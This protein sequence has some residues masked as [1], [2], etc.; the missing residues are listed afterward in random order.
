MNATWTRFVLG[1]LGVFA[2][3]RVDAQISVGPNRQ[4]ST[5]NPQRPHYELWADIDPTNPARMVACSFVTLE[6]GLTTVVYASG[7]AGRTWG[8]SKL[9]VDMQMGGD[10]ICTFGHDGMAYYAVLGRAK[11]KGDGLWGMWV[12]RSS[13][14]G[15]MWSEPTRLPIIDREYVV[16]DGG[17]GKYHGRVYINGTGTVAMMA[18]TALFT[19]I[20]LYT[21]EDGG[22]TFPGHAVRAT[23]HSEWVFGM[24][25]S[26]VMSDGTVA[27]LFGV[28]KDRNDPFP[29]N[30]L[31]KPNAWLRLIT[32][33]DGGASLQQCVTIDDWYIG[34]Q[35][36]QGAII[37]QL[38]VDEGNSPF[39]DRL[40]AVWTDF[41]T[42]RLE[43]RLAYSANKGRMWSRSRVI[44]DDRIAPDP[45]ASGPDAMTPIIAVNKRG[46]VGVAWYDRR[47]NSDNL[48]WYERFSASLDGGETWLPSVRVSEQPNTYAGKETWPLGADAAP[49]NTSQ[50]PLHISIAVNPFF[51]TGGHTGAVAADSNGTFWPFWFDNRTGVSQIWTAPVTVAGAAVRNGSTNL[52]MLDD[53]TARVALE[54]TN[55]AYDRA[56]NRLTVMAKLKNTSKDTVQTPVK[57]RVV[58]LGSDLGIPSLVVADNGQSGPGAV[59]DLSALLH[60][61]MLLPDSTSDPRQLVFRLTDLRP[62]RQGNEFKFSLIDLDVRVLAKVSKAHLEEV[63]PR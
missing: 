44:D 48:G 35:R 54:L 43:I 37:P 31:T 17:G 16:T 40:Y 32:S 14:G 13:D 34:L 30:P 36:S 5:P 26:V 56:T 20:E 18:D 29:R 52:S 1:I 55:T 15:R 10:P 7:D 47:E 63:V 25:N 9:S 27:S 60:A 57:V 42:G 49:D 39:R 41:R 12:Y 46:V 38:A 53:V 50:R 59:L 24:G 4:V 23:P 58:Q 33:T 28:L 62:F 11:T 21:S 22:R 51:Y 6:S 2:E 8:Q 61:G 45:Q 3:L 19:T